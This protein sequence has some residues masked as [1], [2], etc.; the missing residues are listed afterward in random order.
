MRSLSNVIY[1]AVTGRS[2][3]S[4]D[5]RYPEQLEQFEKT[6]KPEI[7][8]GDAAPDNIL[9]EC[10]RIKPEARPT[11]RQFEEKLIDYLRRKE[12]KKLFP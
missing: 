2:L 6:G 4:P 7:Q 1:E 9:R 10:I 12:K 5:E 11:M 3:F 8:T